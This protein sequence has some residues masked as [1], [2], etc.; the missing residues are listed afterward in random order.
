MKRRELCR[1]IAASLL[2]GCVPSQHGAPSV[3]S[4]FNTFGNSLAN[5]VLSPLM[6]AAGLL[7]G[8]G[9]LTLQDRPSSHTRCVPQLRLPLQRRLTLT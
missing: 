8:L 6:I 2:V 1:A 4:G 5:L 3:E 7:E 9:G